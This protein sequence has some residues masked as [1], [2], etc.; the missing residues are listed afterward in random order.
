M[1]P[2]WPLGLEE[3][4]TSALN[5]FNSNPTMKL[6][7][8]ILT[9]STLLLSFTGCDE[10]AYSKSARQIEAF[11][12]S[13]RGQVSSLSGKEEVSLVS[14]QPDYGIKIHFSVTNKGEA[15]TIKIMP[16]LS[17]SEGEWSRT[18]NLSFGKGEVEELSYFF[19]E[20]TINATNIRFGVK[21]LPAAE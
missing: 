14:D 20:P 1:Q 15:G 5:N 3:L 16:W 18:Q 12:S 10:Q 17:C 4:K 19:H 11:A 13:A 21:L 9:L 2:T 7:T 6:I 8:I